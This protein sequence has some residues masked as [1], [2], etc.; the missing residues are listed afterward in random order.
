[1]RS[2]CPKGRCEKILHGLDVYVG[3]QPFAT[4][5]VGKPPLFL[6]QF[7]LLG[8]HLVAFLRIIVSAKKLVEHQS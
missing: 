1:M 8:N 7:A 6:T 3:R 5:A 2:H 4:Q